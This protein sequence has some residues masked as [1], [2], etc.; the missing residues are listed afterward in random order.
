ML[1]ATADLVN[2]GVS[3]EKDRVNPVTQREVEHCS[4]ET[5]GNLIQ[6]VLVSPIETGV[7]E[8]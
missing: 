6:Q 2:V 4:R 3:V 1:D 7:V 8:E 5:R